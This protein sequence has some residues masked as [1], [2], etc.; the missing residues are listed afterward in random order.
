[1]TWEMLYVG[2]SRAPSDA[3]LRV[4]PVME[5]QTVDY[6]F[7]MRPN[8]DTVT[9]L[10]DDAWD[11]TGVRV[12]DGP[13]PRRPRA[14]PPAPRPGPAPKAPAAKP[15]APPAKHALNKQ[16]VK[17][18]GKQPNQKQN[19]NKNI[20]ARP[21]PKQKPAAKPPAPAGKPAGKPAPKQAAA[22][23]SRDD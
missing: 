18:P 13:R 16:P 20:A 2:I 22:R 17:A 7:K 4:L 23:R 12:F 21:A 8:R 14:K 15:P 3:D 11:E 19:E 9:Y 5:G 1:M 10:D 6:L